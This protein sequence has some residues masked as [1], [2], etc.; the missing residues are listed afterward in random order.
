MIAASPRPDEKV[1]LLRAVVLQKS[2]LVLLVGGV[3]YILLQPGQLPRRR[4]RRPELLLHIRGSALLDLI[5]QL[6]LTTEFAI[7]RYRRRCLFHFQHLLPLLIMSSC[8][9]I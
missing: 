7:V 3:A 8:R 2:L 6:A 1:I 5:Q 4:V 9:L